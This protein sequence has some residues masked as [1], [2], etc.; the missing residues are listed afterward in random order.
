ML[1]VENDDFIDYWCTNDLIDCGN[2]YI[3]NDVE[4]Y[5]LDYPEKLNNN[6]TLIN[7]LINNESTSDSRNSRINKSDKYI[8]NASNRLP[9]NRSS[10]SKNK[11][12]RSNDLPKSDPDKCIPSTNYTNKHNK[13]LSLLSK[14][15]SIPIKTNIIVLDSFTKN[16][17]D[18]F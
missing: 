4:D 1:L 15:S 7:P 10:K 3:N 14:N 8:C 11:N 18:H 16:K 9:N 12:S 5:K 13:E 17:L 6:N 2:I